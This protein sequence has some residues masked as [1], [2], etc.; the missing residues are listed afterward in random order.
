MKKI[1]R[2]LGSLVS[3]LVILAIVFGSGWYFGSAQTKDAQTVVSAKDNG[4][5]LRLPGEAEERVVT[6]S[7]VEAQLKKI[8]ELAVHSGEYSIVKDTE[9]TRKLLDRVRI[10]GTTN[11]I[12]LECTGVV[13]VGFALDEITPAVENDAQK[14]YISLPEPEVLV[15]YVIWDS[16][17]CTVGNN[18][19][20]PID[21][22]QY[23][24]LIEEVEQEGLAQ[25]EEEGI[26]EEAEEN[27]KAVIREFLSGFVGYEIVFI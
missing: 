4:F 6:R 24:T 20:N 2:T 8:G 10:P 14:I 11:T 17:I 13:K 3:V 18:P 21:F 25:V 27:A 22:E 9:N 1:I 5:D 16:V 12:H 26:Y 19:L 7:E 23:R 15:N